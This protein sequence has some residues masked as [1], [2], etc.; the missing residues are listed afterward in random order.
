[1]LRSGLGLTALLA[2]LVF[3]V[4]ASAESAADKATARQVA[5]EGI[6]LYKAGKFSEA[7]DRLRR[8]QELYSAPVHLLYIAR[9]EDKLTELVEAE[10][11]YRLL[12]HYTLPAG[13]PAAWV[14]AVSDGQKELAAL[15]PR[16]PKLRILTKP[17]SPPEPKLTIDGADVS[18]AVL[19]IARP[20]NPGAH[21]VELTATGYQTSATD[22]TLA[23]GDSKDVTLTLAPGEKTE[24]AAAT[25]ATVT[26]SAPHKTD[27]LGGVGFM[28]GLRLGVGIPTGNLY[29]GTRADTS[30]GTIA[31]SDL[32]KA[33]GALELHAGMR[34]ARYFTPVIYLELE[35]LGANHYVRD[36]DGAGALGVGI[37]LIVGSR[38]GKVGGFGEL[39]FGFNSFS[40]SQK[41]LIGADC[42]I[43]ASG[44]ALRLGGGAVIPAVKWLNITPVLMATLGRFTS[45][46]SSSTCQDAPKGG[47]ISSDDQRTHGMILLGVGGDVILG[48]DR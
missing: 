45:L 28:G 38:P 25:T 41:T 22:V 7:L 1:M 43:S 14:S 48:N 29:A 30:Q 39:D 26:D 18:S 4:S 35:S 6:E 34:F 40:V 12:D 36:G 2:S 5:T 42:D 20:T 47:D 31:T 33:G 15:E 44:G 13:A 24:T 11:S 32:F 21:H 3:T 37:G 17:E 27:E 10:E 8:A 16:I 23:E 9:A 19:G 46:K